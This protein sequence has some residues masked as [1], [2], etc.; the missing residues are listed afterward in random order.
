MEE[1]E[2]SYH[3][4][5]MLDESVKGLNIQEGGIYVDVTFGG[6]GHSR[7]ILKR[8]DSD[9]ELYGFDQD[10]DAEHNIPDDP[11]FVFVRSNFRYLYNFMRYHG[12]D[13]EVDGLL[14]DLGVSSHHFDDK[15]RG[16][17][18]RFDGA[19][20][21]RM[22]TRA[23]Q[24]AAD[25][26][27]TYT[28]EALAD[29]FYLYGELKVARRL[30]S[31]IV[32]AREN[33]KIETIGDFLELVKPF[34]GKDKEKKFLAQVFQAL[35]IE[36]NDEMRALKEMLQQTLQVLK[37]GG[38]LVVITYHSL[39]DRL[40]KNF[41][42]TGNFE[43]KSEQD[44]FGNVQTPFRMVNNKVIVPSDEEIERNP[45]SRSAKL[46]IAEKK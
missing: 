14:A 25:I 37:P 17:S 8:M 4:P 45:R 26:V 41:L 20:D 42:K 2:N 46:R 9:S 32:R 44:F 15:D 23:G 38:R 7:E 19:L 35:R 33:K 22:N 12:V 10:A 43:G 31:L 6:G 40:V 1:K 5:V 27:N 28:E 3:V 36:V 18:F 13:G 30:A 39:E 11:R 21:M 16:F 24:T 34:T 29:V